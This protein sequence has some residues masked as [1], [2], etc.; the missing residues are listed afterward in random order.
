M[1]GRQKK[2]PTVT[3]K[4][5]YPETLNFPLAPK[6]IS[7]VSKH[8][9]RM[10]PECSPVQELSGSVATRSQECDLLGEPGQWGKQRSAR[11]SGERW[12]RL[13]CVPLIL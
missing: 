1:Y 3:L 5:A 10:P 8:G 7:Y 9:P 13:C 11:G 6:I 12:W 2:N 4:T